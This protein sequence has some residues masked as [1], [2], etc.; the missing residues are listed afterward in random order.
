VR[1]VALGMLV[2]ATIAACGSG[3]Q[4]AE[5]KVEN[6]LAITGTKLTPRSGGGWALSVTIEPQ[7]GFVP[8]S[9][10][11]QA[12]PNPEHLRLLEDGP[13]REPMTLSFDLQCNL[14][15]GEVSVI[16]AGFDAKRNFSA[17]AEMKIPLEAPGKLLRITSDEAL[18]FLDS[19]MFLDLEVLAWYEGC[20]L[21]RDVTRGGAT[22]HPV[23][24]NVVDVD[25]NGRVTAVS[26]GKT[27]IEIRYEDA[28]TSTQ[29]IVKDVWNDNTGGEG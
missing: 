11:V 28:T 5:G 21:P 27:Y 26:V 29:A 1:K 25:E 7:N 2:L 14:G 24:E 4:A 10:T 6:G 23:T 8:Q 20:D 3:Q 18:T 15:P 16:V 12:G 17:A 13:Y 22:Y 19:T 9:I